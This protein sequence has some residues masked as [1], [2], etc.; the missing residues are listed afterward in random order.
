MFFKQLLDFHVK[1]GHSPPYSLCDS[2]PPVNVLLSTNVPDVTLSRFTTHCV[3]LMPISVLTSLKVP[4]LFFFLKINLSAIKLTPNE[5]FCCGLLLSCLEGQQIIVQL[6]IFKKTWFF[7]PSCFSLCCRMALK[8]QFRV[9]SFRKPTRIWNNSKRWIQ[10]KNEKFT[11][12]LEL[13]SF[14]HDQR[15]GKALNLFW[16]LATLARHFDLYTSGRGQCHLQVQVY[17]ARWASAPQN[18]CKNGFKVAS[19]GVKFW[20]LKR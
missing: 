18:L 4:A 16:G 3:I 13:N 8:W 6:E 15:R 5:S 12:P 20:M 11:E 10:E 7:C 2:L 9:W 19:S 14:S 17:H 1:W